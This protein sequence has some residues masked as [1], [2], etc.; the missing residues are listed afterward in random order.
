MHDILDLSGIKTMDVIE[1][2][3]H[4]IHCHRVGASHGYDELCERNQVL[5]LVRLRCKS[6]RYLGSL[7]D[8]KINTHLNISL[9][10]SI[11]LEYVEQRT[12][13]YSYS[14][15]LT[16]SCD[17][18]LTETTIAHRLCPV[19]ITLLG[20]TTLTAIPASC[21]ALIALAIWKMYVHRVDSDTLSG[22]P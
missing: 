13:A 4:V 2:F 3:V 5:L 8:S 20:S 22:A 18:P 14:S 12:R 16:M 7:P 1:C 21:T 9:L 17:T 6:L 11:R 15:A 10:P 19:L